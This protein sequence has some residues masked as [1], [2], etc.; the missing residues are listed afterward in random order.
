MHYL[1]IYDVVDDYVARRAAFRD[2]HL[3][4]AW[5][6]ADRGELLLGGALTDPTDQ[7][8]LLFVGASSEIAEAFARSDPYVK[9]GLV[10][11]WRVRSWNTVAGEAASM[12]TKP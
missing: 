4:L 1:L 12:P 5:A 10:T 11:R 8:I 2:E 6:A 3:T 9:N 7:A